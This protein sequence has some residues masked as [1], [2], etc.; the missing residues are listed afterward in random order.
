MHENGALRPGLIH[1]QVLSF[2][3]RLNVIAFFTVL[4]EDVSVP[5]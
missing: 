1:L 3:F 4:S 2:E 5:A